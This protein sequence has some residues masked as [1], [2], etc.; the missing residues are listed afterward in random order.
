M[1]QINSDDTKEIHYHDLDIFTP[2]QAAIEAN[3]LLSE[4]PQI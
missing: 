2:R 3:I 4:Y 1:S